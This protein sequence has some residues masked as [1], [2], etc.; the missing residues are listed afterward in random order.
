SVPEGTVY[1]LGDHRLNA[2]DSRY[3]GPVPIEK[4]VGT[5]VP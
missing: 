5:I 1:V 2:I 4:I 3:H